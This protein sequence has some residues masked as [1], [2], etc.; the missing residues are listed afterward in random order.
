[1]SLCG[2]LVGDDQGACRW[3]AYLSVAVEALGRDLCGRSLGWTKR[4]AHRHRGNPAW[5]PLWRAVLIRRD[6]LIWI[7]SAGNVHIDGCSV[8]APK[9]WPL[10]QRWAQDWLRAAAG[11][12]GPTRR[13]QPPTK[14]AEAKPRR[15]GRLL[16]QGKCTRAVHRQLRQVVPICKRQ[17][18]S[19]TEASRPQFIAPPSLGGGHNAKFSN[20]RGAAVNWLCT[21]RTAFHSHVHWR[22]SA[23]GRR[24]FCL[25]HGGPSFA[26]NCIILRRLLAESRREGGDACGSGTPGLQVTASSR[27][28]KRWP[29]RQQRVDRSVRRCW[30]R[31]RFPPIVLEEWPTAAVRHACVVLLVRGAA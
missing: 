3:H 1:M 29:N 14:Q 7:I 8:A 17:R 6:I 9:L 15:H 4:L 19:R 21:A 2:K 31:L 24:S 5:W 11:R 22:K 20:R 26:P 23:D 13:V 12:N 18:R 28:R 16:R 27:H 10:P 30:H 25:A